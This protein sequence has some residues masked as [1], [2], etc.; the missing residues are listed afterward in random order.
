MLHLDFIRKSFLHGK[1]STERRH[2]CQT[3]WHPHHKCHL[4]WTAGLYAALRNVHIIIRDWQNI[5]QKKVLRS[6][7]ALSLS[8]PQ[9]ISHFSFVFPSH[10]SLWWFE[11]GYFLEAGRPLNISEWLFYLLLQFI[12]SG[13]ICHFLLLTLADRPNSDTRVNASTDVQQ[14][15]PDVCAWV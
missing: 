7:G 12:F 11:A 1:T 9:C 4:L 14:D 5:Q 2:H 3:P 8:I 10:E 15:S 13:S 6:E